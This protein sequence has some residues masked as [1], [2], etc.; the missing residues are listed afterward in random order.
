[1]SEALEA[2]NNNIDSAMKLSSKAYELSKS[3][4]ETDVTEML[5]AELVLIISAFDKYLHDVVLCFIAK[6]NTN[7]SDIPR[8]ALK[9]KLSLST[10]TNI[11]DEE[12]K[13]KRYDLLFESLRK[14]NQRYTYQRT[15]GINMALSLCNV[16]TTLFWEQLGQSLELNP[17]ELREK[18]DSIVDKRNCIA[19]QSDIDE[20]SGQKN[21]IDFSF[22]EDV[23][24]LY[25][26]ITYFIDETI[27]Q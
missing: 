7:K 15:T 1:M 17:T 3:G 27:E 26:K 24:E 14:E 12:D 16:D 5:R 19:H 23:R 8:S 22:I 20:F 9:F 6:A 4:M 2:Y 18:I 11:I 10:I 25:S 21:T 13:N